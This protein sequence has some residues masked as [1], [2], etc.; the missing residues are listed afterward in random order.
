MVFP[1]GRSRQGLTVSA[2]NHLTCHQV[3]VNPH[4]HLLG[5]S[6]TLI[7]KGT[8]TAL[9]LIYFSNSFFI[10]GT[11]KLSFLVFPSSL[12]ISSEFLSINS[13]Q[14]AVCFHLNLSF[15]ITQFFCLQDI[16]SLRLTRVSQNIWCN[17]DYVTETIRK[18]Y[19]LVA[20]DF[21][22][23]LFQLLWVMV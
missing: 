5:P 1:E 12:A 9:A 18:N 8:A 19:L 16:I 17:Y 13:R 11:G 20:T 14:T 10:L 21:T 15:C 4:F 22:C 7:P 3:C 2:W 23:I 6:F